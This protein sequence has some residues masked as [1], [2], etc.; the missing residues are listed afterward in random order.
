MPKPW[1]KNWPESVPQSIQYPEIPL[2]EL[3]TRTANLYPRNVAIVFY[4]KRITYHELD[5]LTSD[6]AAA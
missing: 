1:L 2:Y 6:F 5:V 3:L 4:G